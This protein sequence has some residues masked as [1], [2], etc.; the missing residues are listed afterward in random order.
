MTEAS[1]PARLR[2]TKEAATTLLDLVS[3]LLICGGVAAIYWPAALIL[4]GM[5]GLFASWRASAGTWG[6]KR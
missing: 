4:A 2:I 3:V 1:K 6:R 5:A